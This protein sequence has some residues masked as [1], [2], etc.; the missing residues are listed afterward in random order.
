[1]FRRTVQ[2]TEL[3]RRS[4]ARATEE[5]VR[6][7]RFRFTVHADGSNEKGRFCMWAGACRE[8]PRVVLRAHGQDGSIYTV[9]GIPLKDKHAGRHRHALNTLEPKVLSVMD[10]YSE[11]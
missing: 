10:A 6:T 4:R 5:E 7:Y 2:I 11:Y 9:D 8:N 1:M 3:I